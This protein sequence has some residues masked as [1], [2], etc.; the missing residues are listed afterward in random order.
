M[1]SVKDDFFIATTG[2]ARHWLTVFLL[3]CCSAPVLAQDSMT[4]QAM[5]RCDALNAQRT[6]PTDCVN[7]PL[8]LGTG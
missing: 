7:P 5:T 6:K 2:L 1:R 3:A 4:F 8:E